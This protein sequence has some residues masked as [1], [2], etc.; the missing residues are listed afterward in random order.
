[1]KAEERE[2]LI[3]ELQEWMPKGTTVYTI[4][5]SVAKSG[6]SRVIS[7]VVLEVS[8]KCKVCSGKRNSQIHQWEYHGYHAS[9]MELLCSPVFPEYK[10]AKLLGWSLHKDQGIRVSGC[11]MDMGFHLVYTLSSTLY[12]DGNALKQRWL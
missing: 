12:G 11:G 1:M 7:P 2:Q 9:E 6:M 4:I 5:R 8:E 3:K 10:I